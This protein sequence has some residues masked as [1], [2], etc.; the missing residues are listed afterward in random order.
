MTIHK[1]FSANYLELNTSAA[2]AVE[3][4]TMA[5]RIVRRLFRNA[6]QLGPAAATMAVNGRTR[7]RPQRATT[8]MEHQVNITVNEKLF[9]DYLARLRR[10]P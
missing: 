8:L 10:T 2:V 7:Y 1:F 3:P 6:E 4:R 5:Q 9:C